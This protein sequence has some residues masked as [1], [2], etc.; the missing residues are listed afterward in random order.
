MKK[1]DVA[2]SISHIQYR[3][4]GM[5]NAQSITMQAENDQPPVTMIKRGASDTLEKYDKAP[6]VDRAEAS[7]KKFFTDH[8]GFKPDQEKV[9]RALLKGESAAAIFPAGG[10]N[11]V[12]YQLP[13]LLF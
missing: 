11:N 3:S 4:P 5:K 12:R 6:T 1:I 2:H 9:I 10:G 8:T 7:L 13:N